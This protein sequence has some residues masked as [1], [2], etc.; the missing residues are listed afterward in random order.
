[1]VIGRGLLGQAEDAVREPLRVYYWNGEDPLDE[2]ERRIAAVQLFYGLTETELQMCKDNLFVASG[3]DQEVKIAAMGGA[4]GKGGSNGAFIAVPMV[5]AILSQLIKEAVDVVILD[6]FVSTHSVSENDN[7]AIDMVVKQ[8][9][10]IADEA[11][12]AI[13]LVHHSRKVY[14]DEVTVEDGRGASALLAAVRVARAFNVMTKAQAKKV[15]AHNNR[16]Y[17]REDNGKS[18]MAPPPDGARW[19]R[20][21][22]V[23][24]GNASMT[25]PADNVATVVHWDW[26]EDLGNDLTPDQQEL[27]LQRIRDEEPG[28][29]PRAPDWVGYIIMDVLNM[30]DNRDSRRRAREVLADLI[31]REI[32]AIVD[33]TAPGQRRNR[34]VVVV[35]ED[36]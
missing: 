23:D 36:E 4:S 10:K 13:D 12:C 18:N 20:L 26:P 7:N 19:Y 29:G 9:A 21:Q 34:P 14:G 31:E 28:T 33:R 32:V 35:L 15:G 16:A 11:N 2:T 8:W 5:K 6:P 30:A 25:G 17:F 3:R 22:G 27:I 1:M 24:L